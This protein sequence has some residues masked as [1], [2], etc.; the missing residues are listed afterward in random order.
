MFLKKNY[1]LFEGRVKCLKTV[2]DVNLCAGCYACTEICPK[3]AITVIDD[4]NSLNAVIDEKKC[5]HCKACEKVCQQIHPIELKQPIAWFQ[6][7]CND[8][9][10]RSRS[11][12]GGFAYELM[13][14][15][16]SEGGVVCSCVY[17]NTHFVYK[18]ASS[19]VD[20]EKYR[21]SKYVKS[22]PE[23]IY[24]EIRSIID[25]HRKVLFIGLPCHVAGLK[26]YLGKYDDELLYTADL[27]CHGSP[28]Q[29]LLKKFLAEKRVPLDSISNISFRKKSVFRLSYRTNNSE[30]SIA[31]QG[32][33][34]RFTIGFLKGLFYTK[35]CYSCRYAT[36]N[37]VS[38]ITLGDSWG[39]SL[40]MEEGRKGISL[41]ICQTEKGIQ[42]LQK[43]DIKLMDVNIEKVIMA[44]HQ[45]REPSKM[46]K[47]RDLFFSLIK[48]G[49]TINKSIRRCYPKM[50]FRQSI[51]AILIKCHLYKQV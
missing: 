13:K 39:S 12:S 45:L 3:D 7:W 48:A 17:N 6:G 36:Q 15:F 44:N 31:P 18:I 34:D 33:R 20:L 5:I 8:D 43:S 19:E 46:T 25:S 29:K 27:I 47:E 50:C 22:N 30:V 9:S 35:N 40:G 1:G 38:D 28:S 23:G 51:K 41:A 10:S 2:C 26:C 11:S 24:S 32:V 21:G 14:R 4:T 37:R 16:I 42:L 49:N